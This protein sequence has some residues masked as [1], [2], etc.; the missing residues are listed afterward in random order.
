MEEELTYER[1]NRVQGML[2][3]FVENS[4]AQAFYD[5]LEEKYNTCKEDIRYICGQLEEKSHL[6]FQGYVQFFKRKTLAWLKKNISATAN[7]GRQKGTNEQARVYCMKE[8]TRRAPFKEY[9]VYC[10][11]QGKRN[12][13]VVFRDAIVLGKRTRELIEEMPLMVAK[14]PRFMT[15]LQGLIKPSNRERVEV[16]LLVG[17][18][19]A[20][21]THWCFE[22]FDDDLWTLPLSRDKLWFDGYSGE[23]NVLIDDFAGKRSKFPLHQLLRLLDR[24]RVQVE[25][26][27]AF[28]WFNPGHIMITSNFHPDK[29][30]DFTESGHGRV[31]L[32]ALARRVTKV[33]HWKTKEDM[34]LMDTPEDVQL[35][36][37]NVQAFPIN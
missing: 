30:Y 4:E 35:Y 3:C 28:S 20:G 19:G 9:G 27:G 33:F 14:Y 23:E 17:S 5:N 7:F 16:T 31:Q 11:G 18:T 1:N 32:H 26:K 36:F 25:I 8:D 6:H 29:W 15:L 2:W 37:D 34:R 10:E 13:I 24:W 22:H 21:K 12:D